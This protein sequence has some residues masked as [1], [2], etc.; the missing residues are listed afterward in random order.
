M[1]LNSM[2]PVRYNEKDRL[3][4]PL[5]NVINIDRTLVRNLQ[6]VVGFALQPPCA[7]LKSPL[8]YHLTECFVYPIPPIQDQ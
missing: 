3:K 8:H 7:A 2:E 6:A 1:Y 5:H 4:I